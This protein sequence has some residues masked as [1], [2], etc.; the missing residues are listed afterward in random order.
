MNT[1]ISTRLAGVALLAAGIAAGWGFAHWTSRGSDA[2]VQPFAGAA[3]QGT[4]AAR[5]PLYWYD[6]MKPDQHF[7]KPG[8]SPFMDM[9]LEPRYADEGAGDASHPGVHIDARVAQNLGVRLVTAAPGA[10]AHDLRAVG[11]VVLNERD[12]GIVQS[13]TAGF[14]E[15]V[16]NLA[17][18][19]VVAAGAPLA[20]V[21]TPEWAG[22]QAEY[23]AVRKTG[24]TS[25]T[26]A[27]RQRLVLL[28]MPAD[29][30]RRI[31][32]SGQPAP[33]HT[34]TVPMP[35]VIQELGVRT[36]MTLVPGMTL[37]RINGVSSVWLDVAVPEAQ[38]GTVLVG[39][40]VSATL[41]AFVGERFTGKVSAVLTEGNRDA[42]T[43][44]LRI[45]LP[46]ADGR[47]KAGMSAEV[48]I[49]GRD[50]RALL[51]AAEAVIRTGRRNLVYVADATSSGQGRYRP[52]EVQLGA[53]DD[54]HV[55]VLQGLKAG[56][57]VVASGQFLIDSEASMQ[58]LEVAS[59][60]AQ[61]PALAPSA[62]ASASSNAAATPRLY[63]ARGVI[64]ELT[65]DEVTLKHEAVPAL[66][67]PGMTMPFQ[68]AQ[69]GLGKAFKVG[70][71]V[72]FSFTNGDEGAAIQRMRR[73][74][75]QPGRRP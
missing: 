58:G 14:V 55:A 3:P 6:P 15:R 41:P 71:T 27:A 38:A 40:T 13:R 44:K 75:A 2:A 19:D 65:A 57:Q 67:W 26:Q 45:A 9:A 51:I 39:Q 10:M 12:V 47:L 59:L 29:L 23:L 62:S 4:T 66:K 50:E 61:A 42:R 68:L 37:A 53:E 60:G 30:L 11:T 5:Q 20:D 69:P 70:D 72:R 7:D 22:A 43:L 52:V 24:D 17:P 16:Y 46:N 74:A 25:L 1:A 54:G 73:E 21:L 36:G 33:S 35:G 34:I 8:K 18:G 63:E 56:D 28:G 31:E 49:A 64:V 32:A 48:N